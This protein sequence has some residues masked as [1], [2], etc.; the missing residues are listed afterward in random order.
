MASSETTI[1]KF[2]KMTTG[3]KDNTWGTQM[4]QLIDKVED[5]CGG[6]ATTSVTGNTDLTSATYWKSYEVDTV[7]NAALEFTDGGLSANFT[8][9]LPNVNRIYVV[10]NNTTYICTLTAGAGSTTVNVPVGA[11]R[12]Y[13]I[14][15]D[16]IYQVTAVASS[17]QI[18]PIVAGFIWSNY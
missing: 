5:A 9:T 6:L 18:D 4:N 17:P 8:I 11:R 12:L 15:T 14:I 3:E 10:H 13:Q 2:E 7:S 1:F 16:N